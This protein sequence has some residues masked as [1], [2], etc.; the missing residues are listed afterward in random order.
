MP[1]EAALERALFVKQR[2]HSKTIQPL[3][4]PLSQLQE[5]CTRFTQEERKAVRTKTSPQGNRLYLER[6]MRKFKHKGTVENKE[7]LVVSN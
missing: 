5:W 3:S 6:S 2:F 7:I 4:L 1:V